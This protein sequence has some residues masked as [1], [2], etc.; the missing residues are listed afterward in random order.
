MEMQT[1]TEQQDDGYFD[2]GDIV[3]LKSGGPDMVIAGGEQGPE[4]Q[5]WWCLW[6]DELACLQ[7]H[8]FP[9]AILVEAEIPNTEEEADNQLD[10]GI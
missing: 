5:Q 2:V 10:F 8:L 4:G 3:Q 7:R 1:M 9:E 6:F